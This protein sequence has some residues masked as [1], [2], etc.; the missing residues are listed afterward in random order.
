MTGEISLPG[1]ELE[2]APQWE[3]RNRPTEEAP[4]KPTSSDSVSD[5]VYYNQGDIACI[6][7]IEALGD[8]EPFCRSTCLKYL[9]RYQDKE[10][11]LKDLLKA[12]WYL[13]RLISYYEK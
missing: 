9:W 7:A 3:D 2:P 5:P 8:G 6:E 12:R 4:T 11:P 1:N 13:N 10:N